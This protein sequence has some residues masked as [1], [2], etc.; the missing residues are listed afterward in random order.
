MGGK[1]GS[2][3]LIKPPPDEL[4][5]DAEALRIGMYDEAIL[6]RFQSQCQHPF[7][8]VDRATPPVVARTRY[9]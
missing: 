1:T 4:G 7:V 6:R 8:W 3:G 2:V 5:S 9:Q